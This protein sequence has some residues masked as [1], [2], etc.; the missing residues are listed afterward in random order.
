MD[1]NKFSE[2][3]QEAIQ[4]AQTTA[5]GLS[6]QEITPIHMAYVLVSP[7]DGLIATVLTKIDCELDTHHLYRQRLGS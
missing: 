1:L 2:K 4:Q 7:R 6:H 3:A 5:I